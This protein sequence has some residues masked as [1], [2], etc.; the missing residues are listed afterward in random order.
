MVHNLR[1]FSCRSNKSHDEY[2]KALLEQRRSER[3]KLKNDVEQIHDVRKTIARQNRKRGK[4]KS[5]KSNG[6][7]RHVKNQQ[8]KMLA[9]AACSY[10]SAKAAYI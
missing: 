3:E 6:Q 9:K 10:K 5:M 2:R 4:V 1:L 7:N 8:L